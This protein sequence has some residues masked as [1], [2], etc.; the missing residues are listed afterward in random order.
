MNHF[1]KNKKPYFTKF[2]KIIKPNDI[3]YKYTYDN[4]PFMLIYTEYPKYVYK[5]FLKHN[6]QV[7]NETKNMKTGC[8]RILLTIDNNMKDRLCLIEY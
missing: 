5:I 4:D 8:I 1:Y 6:Y 3:I 7:M 2:N